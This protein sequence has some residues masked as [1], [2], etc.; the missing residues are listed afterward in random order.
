MAKETNTA[1]IEREENKRPVSSE[2]KTSATSDTKKFSRPSRPAFRKRRP[3][4]ER[5]QSEFDQKVIDIRRVTRVIAGGRRFSLS[6]AVVVGDRKGRVGVG[7][8]KATDT[9]LAIAKA[10][11]KAKKNLLIVP[12]T[13]TKSIA[14]EVEASYCASKVFIRPTKGTSLVAGSA[15]RNVLELAG[16]KGVSAKILSRSKNKLNIAHAAIKALGKLS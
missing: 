14:H 11:R 9:Q 15:L 12:L 1:T 6:V 10:T 16:V 2:A 5:E 13:E 7:L 4:K 8:G 3:M